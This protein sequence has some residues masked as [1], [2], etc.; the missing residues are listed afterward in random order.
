MTRTVTSAHAAMSRIQDIA[1]GMSYIR[2]MTGLPTTFPTQRLGL[3]LRTERQRLGLTQAQVASRAG[4]ARQKVIQVEQGKP[5]VAMAAYT[6]TMLALGL[7]PTIR[8]ARIRPADYPQLRRLLW[9]QP[10]VETLDER[11]ALGLYERNWDLLEPDRMTP[12]E[13]AL[14]DRLVE[15]HGNGILHV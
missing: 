4:L 10:G 2:D 11:D 5:G 13:R 12:A 8:P 14:L 15:T 7:E 6:A 3:Q 1:S 9:N